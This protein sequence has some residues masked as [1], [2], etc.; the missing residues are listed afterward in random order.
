LTQMKV[1]GRIPSASMVSQYNLPLDKRY[2]LTNLHS[3]VGRDITI[4]SYRSSSWEHLVAE[5]REE[6]EVGLSDGTVK[7]KT[8]RIA[9]HGSRSRCRH[10]VGLSAVDV[11]PL[12]RGGVE[13]PCALVAADGVGVAAEPVRQLSAGDVQSPAATSAG[14]ALVTEASPRPGHSGTRRGGGARSWDEAAAHGCRPR[15]GTARLVNTTV[16]PSSPPL[17]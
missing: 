10:R 1:G 13:L 16:V 15:P 4:Q 2:G 14:I 17:T 11:G 3:I 9:V 8:A 7:F 12:G 5:L 6:L